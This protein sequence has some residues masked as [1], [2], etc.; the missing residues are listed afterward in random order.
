L[1]SSGIATS[2]YILDLNSI[3]YFGSVRPAVFLIGGEQLRVSSSGVGIKQSNP[4]YPL[5]VTGDCN[6]TG[7]Y[8]V[9]GV[10]ISTGGGGAVSSVFTRTGAVVA[11]SGD[12]TAAMVTNA[13]STLG[14]Y[15]DPAWVASLAYS[16]LTGVPTTFA[17]SAH[18]HA[19]AD[20]TSGV[21]ATARLGTGTPS[22]A[23]YLRGDGAWTAAPTDL[24]TSVFGRTGAVTALASDYTPAFIGAAAAVHTHAAADI[25]SGVMAVARLGTGTPSA[26]NYLRGDGSWQTVTGGGGSQS[27]WTNDID[28]GNFTLQNVANVAIGISTPAARLHVKRGNAGFAP[29]NA[30]IF[31]ENSGGPAYVEVACAA[32]GDGCGFIFSSS[33]SSSSYILDINGT[34]QFVSLRPAS[35][36]FGGEKLRIQS[37]GV[38]VQNNNPAYPLDVTGDVNITG[39]YRVNGTPIST[40]GGSVNLL[41][42]AAA[43]SGGGSALTA[44][45]S[46][47]TSLVYCAPVTRACTVTSWT[48]TVDAGTAGFRVWRIAAGTAVPTVANTI[49]TADLAISTGTNLKSTTFTNFSGGVAPTFA[50][51]DVIAIQLNAAAT[52]T[53]ATFSMAAQ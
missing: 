38:G 21:M 29:N 41:V 25:T 15:A 24:V 47:G 26:S 4:A 20:I 36:S 32:A 11:V 33:Y 5:D 17:P 27:P 37:T 10:P 31:C 42:A 39:Q 2:S 48:I 7:Q 6:I 8:R 35:F 46:P 9:N 34:W 14:S 3:W 53:Y 50:V 23:N 19:A 52:A 13:V 49:T 51:G 43:F 18:V 40:G 28:G 16:K 44:G 12:Y 22:A 30:A 1:F 45:S